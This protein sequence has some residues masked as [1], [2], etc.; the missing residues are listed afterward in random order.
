[1]SR[2]DG[3]PAGPA[4]DIAPLVLDGIPEWVTPVDAAQL[5]VRLFSVMNEFVQ[6]FHPPPFAMR[7]GY[8]IPPAPTAGKAATPDTSGSAER[9]FSSTTPKYRFSQVILP[10]PTMQRLLDCVAFYEARPTVFDTWNLSS[11]EP[12]PSVA[13]NFRG[14]PGTGKTLAAH[15]VADRL[16]LRIMSARLSDLESK[17]HGDGPK[18]LAN[19]FA[20]ATRERALLF[21]DEAESLLSRR[22]AQPEQ[23]AESAINSMRTELLQ[24]LD[25]FEG[26][27]VFASN[28]PHSYDAAVE[29]R[30]LH[31]DFDL[32]DR[33]ARIG[34]WRTHL[35]AELP[36]ADDVLI[37]ELAAIDGVSGRDIKAAVIMA[38]IGVARRQ[39]EHVDRNALMTAL[40]IQRDSRPAPEEGTESLQS[41]VTPGHG[42]DEVVGAAIGA[43]G[44]SGDVGFAVA[45]VESDR[46]VT[47]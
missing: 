15:A 6:A 4:A 3:R 13:V 25:A 5:R 42:V 40:E 37:E 31:V 8:G 11:I 47:Q 33:E 45:A 36:L 2:R 9:T 26:L 28:L 44:G 39:L 30:L 16:G 46:G 22:F 29:S 41:R 7:I 43:S 21:I 34:I 10:E 32:P 19:L 38:A 35:P 1:M 14:P 20:A 12:N 18:N 27:V 17:Y 24:A 23:A